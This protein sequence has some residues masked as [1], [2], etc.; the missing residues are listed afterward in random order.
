MWVQQT[1]EW[2]QRRKEKN[3]RQLATCRRQRE[4]SGGRPHPP[5]RAAAEV[6]DRDVRLV[7]DRGARRAADRQAVRGY[8]PLDE[9]HRV[10]LAPRL[11]PLLEARAA[12]LD[13]RAARAG[14]L[15][16]R[17]HVGGRRAAGV[18][19]QVQR[20]AGAIVRPKQ[21]DRDRAAL[22]AARQLA[23][24]VGAAAVVRRADGR[25]QLGRAVKRAGAAGGGGGGR[26]GAAA[27][28]SGVA[29]PGVGVGLRTLLAQVAPERFKPAL[30]CW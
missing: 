6:L 12:Q 15:D 25:Q 14:E 9:V 27:A 19:V 7:D 8:R 17:A 5:K 26:G 24:A 22:G 18:G 30:F 23:V 29:A 21:V 1:K 13:A 10:A 3:K 20:V 2:V 4:R 28:D 16:A 11:V